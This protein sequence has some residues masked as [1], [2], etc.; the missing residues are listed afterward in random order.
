MDRLN[1]YIGHGSLV[2]SLEN[3]PERTDL[4]SIGAE[5]CGQTLATSDKRPD[6]A[7]ACLVDL[8]TVK[9]W[10]G[11]GRTRG[12]CTTACKLPLAFGVQFALFRGVVAADVE[13]GVVAGAVRFVA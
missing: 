2:L 6:A 11:G 8:A 5:S 4:A 13:L 3:V 10:S 12:R 9:Q 1:S 7:C